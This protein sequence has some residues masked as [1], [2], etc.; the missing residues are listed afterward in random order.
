[1]KIQA[2][3]LLIVLL[4]LLI[5]IYAGYRFILG[6]AEVPRSIGDDFSVKIPS[7]STFDEVVALL[8]KEGVVKKENIFRNVA[9]QM[10]YK[11]DPMRSGRYK[12]EPGWTIFHLIRQ[13][14][15]GEQAPV[16]VILTTERTL[17]EVAEKV[18]RFI[19]PD[20]TSL[21]ALF[22][23]EAYL[24]KIGYNR[25]NL[26]SVF[27]PNTYEVYWNLSPESFM[28]RMLLEHKNFWKQKDR[29]AKAKAMGMTPEEV[30]TLASIVEKE[31]LS[32]DEK[33]IIAGTYLNRIKI[34]M[35]LQADPTVVFATRDFT[36]KRV[37]NYHTS[38][39]S[40]FNTYMYAGLPPGPIAMASISSIDAV[41]NFDKNNY[42]YFCAIGDGSGRHA[43]AE[44]YDQHLG[45][46]RTY[47]KNLEARG[48]R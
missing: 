5:G 21:K 39:D 16:K 22:F 19:E 1:M 17:E 2:R 27:I 34:G 25:D 37:T 28:E 46:V 29:L 6:G 9:N 15:S 8:K 48:L 41:L 4:L 38:F 40:P 32:G 44:T 26:M 35:R 36:T 3:T 23:D 47:V 13:L 18:S 12:I 20:S 45:N 33:P 10:G 30:Y 24:S 43:F 42:T 11:Q 14:R 7:N 31:T